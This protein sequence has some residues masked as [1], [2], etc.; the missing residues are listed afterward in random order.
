MKKY[1]ISCF[2]AICLIG[3]E[4][5]YHL[6]R[7]EC[8]HP[9]LDC[10]EETTDGGLPTIDIITDVPT[11]T[12][13]EPEPEPDPEPD[14]EIEPIDYDFGDIESGCNEDTFI[15]I[16]NV[17]TADLIISQVYYSATADL[18]ADINMHGPLPWTIA[19][20]TEIEVQILFEPLDELA[21]LAFM[22]VESNDPDEP[23]VFVTQRGEEHRAGTV[24]DEW[25][26][27]EITKTD[28]LFVVD[29]SGS[30]YHEQVD[31]ASH[32]SDFINA[33]DSLTADYQI[34]VIT[35]DDAS[36]VGSTILTSSP[37]RVADLSSQIV[38]GTSGSPYEKG[39]EYA[40]SATSPGGDA[41][42]ASGFI[43]IDSLLNIIF[44]SDEDDFSTDTVANYVAHFQSLKADP[45]HVILHSVVGDV[46]SGCG[47][48]SAGTRYVDASTHT[49][50]LFYS[51]CSVDWGANLQN[52]ASGATTSRATFTLSEIPL[53]DAVRV[54][55][56]G[57]EWFVGWSYDPVQN[58]VIF[59]ISSIP[60]AGAE[61]EVEY[62]IYG[63]CS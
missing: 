44:I 5:D 26:Q 52:L 57:V 54:Y 49:G 60:L 47:S 8:P 42:A 25:V 40:E 41:T 36:F 4:N 30:M 9:Y 14:I 53:N 27:T 12:I 13:I 19:P 62:G 61:I 31:I 34:A 45:T 2:L 39:L 56:D 38:V 46:P 29:N 24:T 18:S 7:I 22:T 33:L 35:T 15:K 48:A 59:D 58:A 6:T 16:K 43:R 51:I 23:E 17:G 50:G 63:D 55:V 28:I 1:L 10:P 3:C 21:D 37:T 32:A 20:S 11:V